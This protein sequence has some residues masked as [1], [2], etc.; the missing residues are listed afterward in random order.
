MMLLLVASLLSAGIDVSP[1]PSDPAT[2]EARA[3]FEQGRAAY[4]DARFEVARAWFRLAWDKKK[5]PELVFNIAQCDFQLGEHD[6][7]IGGAH[8]GRPPVQRAFDAARADCACFVWTRL[9]DGAPA[10]TTP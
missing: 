9:R 7:A 3:L 6:E 8:R 1:A 4:D 2:V 5:L 10:A